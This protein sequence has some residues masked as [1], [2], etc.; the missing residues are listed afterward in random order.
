MSLSA[1]VP[2]SRDPPPVESTD[3]GFT[4]VS[5]GKYVYINLVDLGYKLIYFS[6]ISFRPSSGLVICYV[7]LSWWDR[8]DDG[9]IISMFVMVRLHSCGYQVEI[10]EDSFEFLDPRQ[11][12]V[13]IPE[14]DII[15]G[16]RGTFRA[17]HFKVGRL[18]LAFIQVAIA[19][20]M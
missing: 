5:N 9:A 3:R 2:I 4:V 20:A 6:V 10:L 19:A 15:R 16:R 17:L 13:C 18:R 14:F 1:I 11:A 12:L 7:K 8:R